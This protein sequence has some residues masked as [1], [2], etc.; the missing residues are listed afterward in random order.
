MPSV[1]LDHNATT[2]LHPA[3]LEAMMPYL[4]THFGNASSIHWAGRA[5]ARGVA[6]AR[7]AVAHFLGAAPPE[8]VFTSGGSESDNLAIFGAI[9]PDLSGSPI[10]CVTTTVEHPAVL[11]PFST[12]EARGIR[13]RRIGVDRSGMLDLDAL[14][15]GI[16]PGRTRL[17]S[18]MFANNETGTIF[19]IERIA[20]IVKAAGALFHCDAVQAAGRIPID[21][22]K[23]PIDLLSLSAHKMYGPKGVGA[24]F[25]RKG[26]KLAPLLRG[27]GQERKRR[28][29]T[30]NTAGIVGFGRACTLAAE[31]M[32][33]E[34]ERLRGLTATFEAA[35][36][37]RIPGVA[38]NTHP[39]ARLPNTLNVSFEG[40]DGESLLFN[41]DLAG[42]A[43]S[44]GSACSSGSLSPSHV[45]RAMGLPEGRV[46][47]AIRF[48]L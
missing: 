4:T 48:S 16:V 20:E 41:L 22:R 10:E 5:A 15:G 21:L 35:L 6:A 24:L 28:A 44:S 25:V 13:V 2:P 26:V 39:T 19:P 27:G 43:A 45:L 11:E 34:S 23:I 31:E 30:E 12:L 29:G 18:V 32:T 14:Q 7:E 36:R 9:G 3:V 46:G 37:A 47:S 33:R 40:A 1:Y 38:V 42:I 17:V 8:I